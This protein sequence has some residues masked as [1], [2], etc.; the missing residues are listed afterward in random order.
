[1]HVCIYA[2]HCKNI[3]V[4]STISVISFACVLCTHHE[5]QGMLLNKSLEDFEIK[6]LI[7]FSFN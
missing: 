3:L 2:C 4:T 7:S 1:M 6:T 5:A